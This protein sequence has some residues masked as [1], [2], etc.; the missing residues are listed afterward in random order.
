MIFTGNR[1]RDDI[2]STSSTLSSEAMQNIVDQL[3]CQCHC[4]STTVNYK[5]VWQ[6][7]NKFFLRLDVKPVKWENRLTLFVGYLIS[8]N[9]K[10]STIRSYI[11]AIRAM[12][13]NGGYILNEDKVLLNSLTGACKLNNDHLKTR[14]PIKRGL[15]YM[16][17]DQIRHIFDRQPYLSWLYQVIFI[18]GYYGLFRVSELMKTLS[19]HQV[20]AKDVHIGKNKNKLLFVLHTSKMHTKGMKP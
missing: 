4:A 7:F 17:M 18:T 1:K 10:S 2:A 16:I 19:G 13:Q 14:F 9:K 8:E 5:S 6:S 15:L 20:R 12:L 3:E 11:S